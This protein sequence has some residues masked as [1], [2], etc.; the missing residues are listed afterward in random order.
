MSEKTKKPAL[1][2]ITDDGVLEIPSKLISPE[3][4]SHL[5][6]LEGLRI[7]FKVPPLKVKGCI[8]VL[9]KK[10]C[11]SGGDPPI[12]TQCIQCHDYKLM[13]DRKKK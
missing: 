1:I 13:P 12:T 7:R 9:N 8:V 3:L 2:T 6:H 11:G 5:Q 10:G 4:Q